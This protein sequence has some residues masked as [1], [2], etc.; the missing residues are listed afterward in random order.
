MPAMRAYVTAG[1]ATRYDHQAEGSLRLD[2]THSNLNQSFHDLL[3]DADVPISS[4]KLKLNRHCGTP[5]DCMEL[6]LRRGNQ[7]DTVFLYDDR[8]SLRQYGA[9]NGMEIHIKDIDPY[10]LSKGGG[11]EDVSLVEKYMMP[12]EAYDKLE[13][14]VRKQVQAQKAKKQKEKEESG[15]AAR[16]AIALEEL[17]KLLEE[18]KVTFLVG[19]RC[20]VQPGSR[21]GEVAYV[22]IP[23]KQSVV[24]VGVRLDEPQGSNNGEINGTRYFECPPGYGC[25]VL[26]TNVTVGDFP[27]TDPFASD[28]E[29]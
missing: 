20:E 27:P 7:M 26:H 3:F 28:D 14:T 1:D 16:E 12:D 29:F 11:L 22:G 25:F 23:K 19:A 10:S 21:R 17:N 13:N 4:V 6:Y 2:V 8:K 5:P 18:V 15:E 9:Q 24:R